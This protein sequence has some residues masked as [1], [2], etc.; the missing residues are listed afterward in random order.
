[1]VNFL[2]KNKKYLIL[3]FLLLAL[4]IFLRTYNFHNWIRFNDD[5][6]RDAIW[7]RNFM[8]G[9]RAFPL[10]GPKAG[11]TEFKLGPVYYYFQY[12][13]AKMF[14][15]S[16]DKL[17]YPDL[18]FSILTIPLFFIFLRKYFNF[19]ESFIVTALFSVSFYVVEYSRFAWN[20]NSMPFFS[21]LFLYS[22]LELIKPE[23]NRKIIWAIVAGIS[24]G[25]GVQLHTL[26]LIVVPV[27]ALLFFF[28]ALKKNF[29]SWKIIILIILVAFCINIPQI[30]HE[31]LTHGENIK[32]FINGVIDTSNKN[33][34][35][36]SAALGDSVCHI[37]ENAMIVSSFGSVR[38]NF[39][40]CHFGEMKK[41]F[42]DQQNAL[43]I[44]GTIPVVVGF[45]VSIIFSIG[46][47]FLLGYFIKR[48]KD[49]QKKVFLY[50]IALYAI[51]SFIALGF[52][53]ITELTSR[54]FLI[55]ELIPFIL[56]GLW[57]RFIFIKFKKYGLKY[58]L[59]ILTILVAL[60]LYSTKEIFASY[61]GDN[62]Q[63]P[64][65]LESVTL[66]DTEF[67][68]SYIVSHVDSTKTA[69]IID[70]SGDLFGVKRAL[71]YFDNKDGIKEIFDTREARK[72]TAT[73][74]SIDL[75]S[76]SSENELRRVG[77]KDY[78]IVDSASHG[79]FTI[80]EL[81]HQN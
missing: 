54:Y 23:K 63:N 35:Y 3:L 5:Q 78:Y 29:V 33:N 56:F 59:L 67:F 27:V 31:T 16:P 20:P 49:F 71:M 11:S 64:I 4:G 17:A 76:V 70:K 46:G 52:L 47:Y 68:Y 21:L 9:D 32:A 14:G 62:L 48:E 57:I 22:L 24:L 40:D 12:A 60:N 42:I 72:T 38:D 15:N 80:F 61:A 1:M 37:R 28:Y 65:S 8:D 43:G 36:V 55:V 53:A 30:Y 75:A 19:R 34:A 39:I 44:I 25:I 45:I 6:A 51:V 2:R 66:E 58:V 73:F 7:A 79:R 18:F 81:K 74:F 26:F 10:L 13:S 69:V 50:L 41:Q 77:L